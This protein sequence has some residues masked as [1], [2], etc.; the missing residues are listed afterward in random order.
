MTCLKEQNNSPVTE[1]KEKNKIPEKEFK[2]MILRK[3]SEIQENTANI[4]R[5]L[6]KASIQYNSMKLGKQQRLVSWEEPNEN[7]HTDEHIE[8]NKNTIKS[9]KNRL[10]QT[11]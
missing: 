7:L 2:I 6:N 11:E 9:F 1:S 8:W 5:I 4:Q 3:L 10:G